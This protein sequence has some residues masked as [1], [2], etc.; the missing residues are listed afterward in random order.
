MK[1]SIKYITAIGLAALS[2]GSVLT[3][4]SLNSN[5]IFGGKAEG[6]SYSIVLDKSNPFSGSVKS[7]QTKAG[8]NISFTATGYQAK[9]ETLLSL[10][11][12]GYISVVTPLNGINDYV[13]EY[14]GGSL[15]S[16]FGWGASE[17]DMI[18][19]SKTAS[20]AS[21]ANYLFD[22]SDLLRPSYIMFKNTSSS[23]L[24]I[25]KITINFDCI[26]GTEPVK[27]ASFP[28]MEAI[29][30]NVK[31]AKSITIGP[32]RDLVGKLNKNTAS[33]VSAL[34]T[35]TMTCYVDSQGN[36]FFTTKC[37][38]MDVVLPSSVKAT[39]ANLPEPTF[40]EHCVYTETT[41]SSML[42]EEQEIV[43]PTEEKMEEVRVEVV[44]DD[45]G[46]TTE[47]KVV[48]EN[49][50]DTG[51]VIIPDNGNTGSTSGSSDGYTVTGF[52]GDC[53]TVI[54]PEGVTTMETWRNAFNGKINENADKIE[55]VVVAS[56]VK[57]LPE[58]IFSDLPNLKTV[59]VKAQSINFG[60]IRNCPSLKCVYLFD[61]VNTI[62]GQAFNQSGCSND[63][64][65]VC[66]SEAKKPGWSNDW[67]RITWG[68]GKNFY[69]VTWNQAY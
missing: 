23:A 40:T 33:V 21:N 17:T 6:M 29:K 49:N 46:K 42:E 2:A 4:A 52:T 26:A 12:G 63:M 3:V 45:S 39:F 53:S 18:W 16:S 10:S 20:G 69:D 48:D 47:I 65:I 36:Y 1:Q 14:T 9:D 61:S 28:S 62:A 57:N 59:I 41:F 8:T 22:G 35:D 54:I 66:E 37:S 27:K 5:D 31:N 55:T 51:L 50:N 58:Y 7:Y 34:S 25:K 13:V 38:S 60:F 24:D 64:Q 30:N 19:S 68:N 15:Q 44:V 56:T 67:N 11:N 32:E 43:V